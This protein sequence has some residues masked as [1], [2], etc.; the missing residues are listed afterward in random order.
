MPAMMGTLL[1]PP[2]LQKTD[3]TAMMNENKLKLDAFNKV[4]YEAQ[5]IIVRVYILKL[6]N[7]SR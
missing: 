7:V 4:E 5:N 2:I 1:P 3:D 6:C